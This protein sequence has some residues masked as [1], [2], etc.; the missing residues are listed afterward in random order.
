LREGRVPAGRLLRFRPRKEVAAFRSF[1]FILV[2]GVALAAAPGAPVVVLGGFLCHPGVYRGI[3]KTLEVV[4]GLP[5]LVVPVS[6]RD[7][8]GAIH[9]SGWKRLL[10]AVE[11]TVR[12]ARRLSGGARPVT[13]VGH[14]SGGVLGRLFLSP[15]PFEGYRFA[16]LDLV[17]HLVTLGSPHLNVRGAR[18]RRWVG[19]AYPGAYFAPDVRYTAVGGRAVRGNREGTP[20]ERAA[21]FLYRRLSGNGDEWGDGLVPAASAWLDGARNLVVDGVAHAPL[22]GTRWYGSSDVIHEW[23]GQHPSA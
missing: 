9:A 12:E 10:L 16:G 6:R 20:K 14:S 1:L 17:R 2:S 13:L 4:I 11:A 23:W 8:L 5:V 3:Q 15:E 18:L 21:H 22:G 19:R 7:W